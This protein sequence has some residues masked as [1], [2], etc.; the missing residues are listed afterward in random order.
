MA[1]IDSTKTSTRNRILIAAADLFA[2]KG[3]AETTVRELSAAIGVKA[4]SI[5]H[6]FPSK[7]AILK[8]L[9]E[10]YLKLYSG[11]LDDEGLY[12]RLREHPTSEGI[13]SCQK[14]SFPPNQ[15]EYYLKVLCVLLQEQHR[16]SVIRDF[17]AE[18]I[19]MRAENLVV[20][21]IEALKRLG[22]IRWDT[23]SDFWAKTTSSLLYTFSN[24]MMLGIGDSAPD[25]MG[26]GMT[27][28]LKTMYDIMLKT[29]DAADRVSVS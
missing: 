11:T 1:G 22:V 8:T 3:Y 25:F 7:S 16:N 12:S 28:V 20:R 15:E 24:R 13:M 27:D 4:S 21:I 10:D 14:L 18:H 19:I 26:M 2:Q 17:M 9:L 6:H 5:Y 23:N 29:C